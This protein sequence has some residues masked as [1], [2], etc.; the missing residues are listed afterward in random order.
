AT[1]FLPG[2]KKFLKDLLL[3][4]RRIQHQVMNQP[5]RLRIKN[6]SAA[7]LVVVGRTLVHAEQFF[8]RQE[9]ALFQSSQMIPIGLAHADFLVPDSTVT[10]KFRK[11]LVQPKRE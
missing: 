9:V 5:P 7:L 6:G 4:S 1:R 10:Q 2:S 3:A 11:P 8:H